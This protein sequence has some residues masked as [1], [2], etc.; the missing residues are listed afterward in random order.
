MRN[1]KIGNQIRDQQ[2]NEGKYTSYGLLYMMVGLHGRVNAL[3][4]ILRKMPSLIGLFLL[5]SLL[6]GGGR[7]G[8]HFG[9][10]I[11]LSLIGVLFSHCLVF[12][13]PDIEITRR[14][15]RSSLSIRHFGIRGDFFG[16]RVCGV[17]A[18]CYGIC[19]G[20]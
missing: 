14:C 2:R 3:D 5:H 9:A 1:H 17:C 8:P 16:L 15:L 7:L 10:V 6:E 18:R 11:L 4:W 20:K 19:G 12:R 13:L